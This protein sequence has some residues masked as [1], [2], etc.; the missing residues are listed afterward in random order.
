MCTTPVARPRSPDS[1]GLK[2]C[3]PQSTRWTS[4]YVFEHYRLEQGLL[5]V[6]RLTRKVNCEL[7]VLPPEATGL[8]SMFPE[9]HPCSQRKT[10]I[11]I[12]IFI[13]IY[14]DTPCMEYMPTL[15]WFWGFNVGIYAIHGVFGGYIYIYTYPTPRLTVTVRPWYDTMGSME[16]AAGP[17]PQRP[18]PNLLA[19]V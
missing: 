16:E 19:P 2:A 11:Y 13:Y 10:Y 14:P 8:L 3:Q 7:R 15:G 18:E 12:Y 17:F 9:T 1:T 4:N 5:I 6:L